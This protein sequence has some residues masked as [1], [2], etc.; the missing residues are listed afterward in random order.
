MSYLCQ[1]YKKTG[2]LVSERKCTVE[3]YHDFEILARVTQ[4]GPNRGL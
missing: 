1:K 2:G 4:H 3:N